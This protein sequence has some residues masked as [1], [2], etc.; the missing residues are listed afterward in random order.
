MLKINSGSAVWG[1]A[2]AAIALVVVCGATT[3]NAQW[4]TNGSNVYY[5]GGN[6]GI[7]TNAP[8]SILHLSGPGG[9]STLTFDSPGA[10]R[11][12]FG[13]IP[14]IANWGA[15]TLNAR[16]SSGW[17]LDETTLPGWFFKLDNRGGNTSSGNT[18]LWLWKVPPGAGTHTDEAAIFGVTVGNAWFAQPVG[19][20]TPLG[21]TPD[22]TL[23]VVGTAHFTGSVTVDGNIAAKYQDV[24]E[25]VP[26]GEAVDAGTVVVVDPAAE[27]TVVASRQ[28]YETS[29]AGVVSAKPGLVLGEAGESKVK[30]AT[31][32]RVKVHVDATRGA[33]KPGDLL[34]T[35]DEPGVAMKSEPV[36]LGGVKIHRPG[37]IVGKALEPLSSGKADILVLL[38][39]Q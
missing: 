10:E 28:A 21:S 27:N 29:V 12:R 32:G 8:Q 35:S 16:Y 30:V 4:A 36:E 11:F 3:A 25:W 26:T 38:S 5:N 9:V 19:I 31:T 17:L 22:S 18:G 1:Y 23:H 15:V 24:A 2:L 14:A 7:G 13:T 39:L 34:V 37:T 20:G 33:I 6:V